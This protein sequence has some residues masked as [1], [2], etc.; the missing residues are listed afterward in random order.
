M[1]ARA[2][3]STPCRSPKSGALAIS[4]AIVSHV[5]AEPLDQPVDPVAAAPPARGLPDLKHRLAG[6]CPKLHS[7]S[8]YD[9]C[10]A[11][12]VRWEE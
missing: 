3:W 4:A 2:A 7:V 9:H 1:R 8:V 5:G 6:D 12:F 10:Q 11:L